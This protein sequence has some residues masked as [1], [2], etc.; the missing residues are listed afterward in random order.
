MAFERG[1]HE[2]RP[3]VALDQLAHLRTG[4]ERGLVV[5]AALVDAQVGAEWCELAVVQDAQRVGVR[6]VFPHCVQRRPQRDRQ[7]ADERR[8]GYAG[9]QRVPV[10][11]AAP[12]ER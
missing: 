2:D 5:S 1:Q 6:D 10:W 11:E 7:Q 12:R 9:A 8:R 3:G 4:V